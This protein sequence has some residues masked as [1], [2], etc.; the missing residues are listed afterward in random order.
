MIKAYV[1]RQKEKIT[2]FTIKGHA[3]SGPHGHDIV[4]AGVSAVVIG[5]ENAIETLCGVRLII[6]QDE[7]EGGFLKFEIPGDL[8]ETT[9]NNV[10]LLLEAMVVSI[11]SIVKQYRPYIQI[12]DSRR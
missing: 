4:C 11:Q 1:D 3:N 9:E 10:Q 12:R 8:E 7:I 5:T 2:S 6:Q